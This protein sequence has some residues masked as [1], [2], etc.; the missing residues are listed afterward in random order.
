MQ[1]KFGRSLIG[2][3]AEG[4]A[5]VL[6]EKARATRQARLGPDHPDTL[7]SM[8]NLAMAYQTAGKRDQA[9][10][11]FD[12]TLRLRKARL[13]PDHPDTLQSMNDVAVVYQDAGKQDLALPL[14]KETLKLMKARLGPDHPDTLN[15]MNSLAW[16]YQLTGKLDLALPL[17]EETLRLRKAKFGPDHPDTLDSIN[18]LAVVYQAAGMRDLALPL[19]EETLRLRKA[20]LGADDPR[21]L[22]SM[23][24]LAMAY[25]DAGKLDLALPLYEETL[26]LSNAKLGT[27]HPLTRSIRYKLDVLRNIG[28]AEERYRVNLAK[29]GPDHIDTLLA[30]RDLAQ[31]YLSTNRLDE[32][33]RILVEVLD[34]MKTRAND[35]PIRVFTIG[36]LRNCLKIRERTMPDSWLT[37]RAKSLLGG[38]LVGLKDYAAAEPL[39][40][41][42]YE[43]MK[44][45]EAQIPPQGNDRLIEAVER[46]AQLYDAT[47][48]KEEA[49]K[50]RKELE[51]LRTPKK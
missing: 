25:Q 28:N 24:N 20:R 34:A 1:D 30:R 22:D 12:E 29:L 2:L 35:D 27:E 39:L 16:A 45:R 18:N 47:N 6:L 36:L 13:G 7:Q 43:G 10:S 11:L 37:F 49:M 51:A 42:G 15:C 33:E 50:W 32:A 40:L 9:L 17:F 46:L 3:R 44:Q 19:F 5:I 26:K 38:A 4:K 31:L 23:N 48:N 8:S 21:T 41:S 14:L